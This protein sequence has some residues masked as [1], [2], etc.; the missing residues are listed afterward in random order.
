MLQAT[1]ASSGATIFTVVDYDAHVQN[2]GHSHDATIAHAITADWVGPF[3]RDVESAQ[4]GLAIYLQ[5]ANGS[6]E[7]PQVPSRH[8]APEGTLERSDDIGRELAAVTNAAIPGA[9]IL[10]PGPVDD[11]RERFK[12]PLENQLFV[13][14]FAL[15]LFPHRLLGPPP[16]DPTWPA[17]RP[18]VTTSVAV[19]RIGALDLIM[20]PGEA[21]PALTK[22]SHWGTDEGCPT[23]SNPPVPAQH[24]TAT[25]RWDV[26]LAD[27]MIGYELPA[28]GWDADRTVYVNPLDPCAF[29]DTAEGGHHH[30]LEDESLGPTAG[31]IIA[32]RLAGLLDRVDTGTR[33]AFASGRYLFAD[34][35]V[36]RRPYVAPFAPDGVV[37]PS[38]RAIGVIGVAGKVVML[39]GSDVAGTYHADG[40]GTFVDYDG[41]PQTGADQQTR[42]VTLIDA[43]GGNAPGTTVFLDVFGPF[44]IKPLTPIPAASRTFR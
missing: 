15:Q 40:H 20:N 6:I 33:D 31:N 11:A 38:E 29:N 2:L 43:V 19:A 27:D 24:S 36:S 17:G 14:A 3:T 39:P 21:F 34:G 5:G 23:R 7:T 35:R 16:I 30:A 37:T 22:G 8:N 32:T 26:G 1:D 13:A 12:A 18:S 10:T 41:R 4:G 28:W 9:E 25:Y 44:G 42:G